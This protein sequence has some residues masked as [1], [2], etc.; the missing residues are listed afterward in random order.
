VPTLRVASG[1][2]RNGEVVF[3]APSRIL[4][5]RRLPR[6]QSARLHDRERH[7]PERDPAGERAHGNHRTAPGADR[8]HGGG[9]RERRQE[10]DRTRA[11]AAGNAEHERR[12]RGGVR[13]GVARTSTRHKMAAANASSAYEAAIE[14]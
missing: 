14:P 6:A 2:P 3:I 11:E 5:A 7:D 1:A 12:P 9:D 10:D 4:V 13:P 8:P